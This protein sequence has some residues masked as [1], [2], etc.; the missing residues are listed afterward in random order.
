MIKGLLAPVHENE[1]A[2]SLQASKAGVK[3]SRHFI[4][5]NV[6]LNSKLTREILFRTPDCFMRCIALDAR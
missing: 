1:F 4:E 5:M 6:I 2:L 3:W